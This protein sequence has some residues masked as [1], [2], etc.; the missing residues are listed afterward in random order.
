MYRYRYYILFSII[1]SSLACQA[2]EYTH[3]NSKFN[4]CCKPEQ[5]PQ[6]PIGE[7]GA[8]GSDGIAGAPGATGPQGEAGLSE[9][10]Y[11]F[12]ATLTNITSNISFQFGSFIIADPFYD[13]ESSST[14]F[15]ESTGAYTIPAT[16]NYSIKAVIN[17]EQTGSPTAIADTVNPRIILRRTNDNAILL[18]GSFPILDYEDPQLSMDI[19]ILA[20]T[21]QVVLAGD[22]YVAAGDILVLEYQADNYPGTLQFGEANSP[23]VVWSMHSLFD[24]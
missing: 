19:R 16:G 8:Q 18:T 2:S 12:S 20:T 17:Y 14:D 24:E 1:C 3:Q 5:G 23:G 10:L 7:Q 11:N 6:G 21:G 9:A 15:N 13:S 22:I 4:A